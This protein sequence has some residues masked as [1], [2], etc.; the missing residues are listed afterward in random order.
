V[1]AEIGGA[2]VDVGAEEAQTVAKGALLARIETRTL[3]ESR[4]SAASSLRSAENQLAVARRETERTERLVEAGALAARELDLARNAV[5]S[6]EAVVADARSR[7]ASAE[8]TLG[9]TVVRAPFAGIVA[10]RSVNL[11]DVVAPGT[12]L[13]RI[14]DPSSM[15]LEASV[16]SE[17]LSVLRVGAA[18]EFRVRGYDRPFEGRIARISPQADA[19]TRQVPI[20]VAIPNVGGK[21]LAG[22]FA[23][24]RVVSATAT[25]LVI[26]SNAV[27]TTDAGPWVLRVSNGTT[28]RVS[29]TLG[30]HDPRSERVQVASGLSEGDTLLRGA[31]QGISP[32]TPVS[33]TGAR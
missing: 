13:F 9:D 24:G 17:D 12:E 20:Y 5:A 19:T 2:I 1:R 33:V 26:P 16:P 23:E 29:V 27:L 25:G 32:G 18:V 3:E 10:A 11:G 22:L 4:Q 8:R 30:L 6:A 31:A 7:L 21:L 15:R 14:I 28:E